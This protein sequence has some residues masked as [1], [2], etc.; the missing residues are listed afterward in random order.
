VASAGMPS[1]RAHATPGHGPVQGF[2]ETTHSFN[3]LQVAFLQS[4]L[5][6]SSTASTSTQLPKGYESHEHRFLAA[7]G[8]LLKLNK[9][10]SFNRE[11]S[12]QDSSE[13][14]GDLSQKRVIDSSESP[15]LK[16][17]TIKCHSSLHNLQIMKSLASDLISINP[18]SLS[19]YRCQRE[20]E[21]LYS[22]VGM[23]TFRC[24]C[25]HLLMVE[26]ES[27]NSKKNP[28]EEALH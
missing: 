12:E 6:C 9:N 11:I 10:T 15:L 4:S 14:T 16:S 20:G 8:F 7:D 5:S 24:C 26:L 3:W 22:N 17:H 23:R 21:F 18:Q 13:V 27:D 28:K 19:R 2:T 1:L 25:M